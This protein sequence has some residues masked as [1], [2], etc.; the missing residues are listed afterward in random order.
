M[1]IALDELASDLAARAQ[2]SPEFWLFAEGASPKDIQRAQRAIGWEF[3]EALKSLLSSANGGFASVDG[4]TSREI[5]LE[6]N[7]SRGRSNTFLAT[8]EMPPAYARLLEAHPDENAQEFPF[9]PILRTAE[10]GLLAVKAADPKGA[11]F[12]AWT[13]E[14]P[15]LWPQL[16]PSL[17]ALLSDYLNRHGEIELDA[18]EDAPTALDR[19]YDD[20]TPDYAKAA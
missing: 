5:P 2:R 7:S 19:A 12:D 18:E 11:V 10:G 14:G 6:F 3:P 4:K 15:H 20:Y 17:A 8:D 16:Y 9:I 1:R 13:A